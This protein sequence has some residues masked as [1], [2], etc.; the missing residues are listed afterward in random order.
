M[1][2]AEGEK[3]RGHCRVCNPPPGIIAKDRDVYKHPALGEGY[4]YESE[5]ARRKAMP[6]FD[7]AFMYFRDALLAVAAFS[8][9][10]NDK[11]N[12]GQPLHWAREKSQ[13]QANCVGRHLLDIGPEWDEI[14]LEFNEPHAVALA[15]RS[16]ALLQ[17]LL[18]A[19]RKGM[20]V[21]EYQKWL[22]EE[23]PRNAV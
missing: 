12:P 20:K 22:R 16:L 13:D 4:A 19:K 15:W 5:S 23:K 1:N 7:G 6:V 10:G 17:T 21:S 9:K 14:D 11:H 8:K 18:E 3:W 2:V